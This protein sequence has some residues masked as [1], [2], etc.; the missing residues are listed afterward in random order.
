MKRIFIPLFVLVIFTMMACEELDEATAEDNRDDLV[1]TWNVQDFSTAFGEQVYTVEI[2]KDPVSNDQ[3]YLYNFA[4][5][6]T[7]EYVIARLQE[8]ELT[9]TSTAIDGNP[10]SGQGFIDSRGKNIDWQY[11]IDY[12]SQTVQFDATFT[13][14]A[15]A[16]LEATVMALN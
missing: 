1:T 5:M 14:N 6:G 9:I 15:I 10:I 4:G 8:D 3:V 11:T 13:T 2:E 7:N 16:G 12:G